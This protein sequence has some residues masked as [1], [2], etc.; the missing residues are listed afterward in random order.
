MDG[1]DRRQTLRPRT[2]K[3]PTSNDQ[4]H[5]QTVSI[6]FLH[7]HVAQCLYQSGLL[8]SLVSTRWSSRNNELHKDASSRIS[9]SSFTNLLCSLRCFHK[10]YAP[11]AGLLLLQVAEGIS[12]ED[13]AR[14]ARRFRDICRLKRQREGVS[15]V[16][17]AS[18]SITWLKTRRSFHIKP[19][20]S[21]S[22]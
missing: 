20:L 14:C 11:I 8:H 18:H 10:D 5:M 7:L 9:E 1:A 15:L 16:L 21:I 17:L 3:T 22:P 19:P 6:S 4:I 12:F 2:Q 13:W